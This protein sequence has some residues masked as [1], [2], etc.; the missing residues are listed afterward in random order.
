VGA[1]KRAIENGLG[2][3]RLAETLMQE[4]HGHPIRDDAPRAPA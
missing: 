1:G 4:R 2:D 3:R